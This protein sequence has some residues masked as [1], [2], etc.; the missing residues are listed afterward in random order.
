MREGSASPQTRAR[1]EPSIEGPMSGAD[2]MPLSEYETIVV[3]Y[4]DGVAVVTFVD[5]VAMFEADKVQAVGKEL[6]DLAECRKEPRI[7]LNLAN[8]HFMSSA[9]LAHLVKLHRKLQAVK[10]RVRLCGLRPVIMD[11]FKV[12]QFDRIFEIFPDEAAALK[13][14]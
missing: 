6:I 2:P 10:G 9:M 4:V 7:L 3:K 8:A 14:F 1:A 12:S 5:S 13:K 11:A